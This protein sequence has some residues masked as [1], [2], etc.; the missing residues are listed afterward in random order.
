M[1][2]YQSVLNGLYYHTTFV[3]IHRRIS[4]LA[5]CNH[6]K[7]PIINNVP[8]PRRFSPSNTLQN[9]SIVYPRKD[10]TFPS[11]IALVSSLHLSPSPSTNINRE[12]RQKSFNFQQKCHWQCT[13]H[14]PVTKRH[15]IRQPNQLSPH[16]CWSHVDP[17][18]GSRDISPGLDPCFALFAFLRHFHHQ[19]SHVKATGKT[20]FCITCHALI[21]HP[22]D[23]KS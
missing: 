17:T 14:A 16:W 7:T 18:R 9:A 21:M 20:R 12:K 10:G 23:P 8:F 3:A 22:T 1:G 2:G 5:Q 4:T 19:L 6:R 11:K 13:C 15:S